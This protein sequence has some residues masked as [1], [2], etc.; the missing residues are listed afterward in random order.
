MRL[1]LP[2]F[3][4]LVLS[5]TAQ[6][7]VCDYSYTIDDPEDTTVEAIVQIEKIYGQETLV[8]RE[9]GSAE[10][11]VRG[12]IFGFAVT[13]KKQNRLGDTLIDASAEDPDFGIS[14]NVRLRV[15]AVLPGEGTLT[16]SEGSESYPSETVYCRN[17]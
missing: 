13:G 7:F 5:S 8:I 9:N 14:L 2:V 11:D 16:Y 6:A 17:R 3:S 12:V 10:G 4:L 15:P 1:M